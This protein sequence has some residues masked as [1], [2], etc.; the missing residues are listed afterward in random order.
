[1]NNNYL[2]Y[3]TVFFT[4]FGFCSNFISFVSP[5]WIQ[6]V[7]EA[8]S[9]FQR[10][11]L[12]TVCFDGY[13][14]PALYD[15]AYFGCYYIYYV[16]YDRVRDWL[17]PIWLYA[18][19]VTSSCGV[20][21]QFLV[22]FVV[23]CQVTGAIPK[24]SPKSLKFV[25]AGHFFTSLT[26]VAALVAF[27]VA[28]YDSRW[29]P[30]PELNILSWAYIVGVL[31]FVSTFIAFIISFVAFIRLDELISREKIDEDLLDHEEKIGIS[32]PPPPP[33]RPPS[34]SHPSTIKDP[35]YYTEPRYVSDPQPALSYMG[36]S[37]MSSKH[38]NVDDSEIAYNTNEQNLDFKNRT[39]SRFNTSSYLSDPKV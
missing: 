37:R 5:Y 22:M 29:M 31:S 20:L 15:K 7:P 6:S 2:F 8:K 23:L 1:M 25:S 14:R 12:W 34:P 28:R 19:Q 11:G 32:S 4:V 35:S 18:I 10:I 21:L 3:C 24:S 17:N 39:N 36:S 33:P 27:A 30:Y 38:W 9:Q 13:M 26:L 16:I